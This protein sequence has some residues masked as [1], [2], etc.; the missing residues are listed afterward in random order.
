MINII[1]C[2]TTNFNI[3]MWYNDNL[4]DCDRFDW[5]FCDCD[6]VYRGNI[7][8]SGKTAGDFT[9]PDIMDFVK[10]WNNTHDKKI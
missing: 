6:C 10:I 4:S 5:C 3:D 1:S 2:I 9:A 8:K 7:Y